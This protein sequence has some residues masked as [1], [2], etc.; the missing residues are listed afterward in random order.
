MAF[1]LLTSM[2]GAMAQDVMTVEKTDGSIVSFPINEVNCVSFS[3]SQVESGKFHGPQRVFAQNQLKAFGREDKYRYELTYDA[4]GF[5]TKLLYLRLND[6]RQERWDIA[7][8]G[9]TITVSI[10]KNDEFRGNGIG[11]IGSNGYLSQCV[12]PGG[13][14][15]EFTYNN[16]EQLTSISVSEGSKTETL[17]FIWQ[18]GNILQGSWGGTPTNISY[19]SDSNSI[20]NVAGVMEYD[21][22]M[23]IDMDDWTLF[24]YIGLIGK[25][26]RQ[27]P[28]SWTHSGSSRTETGTNQWSL[29]AQGRA[30][31]LINTQT[32]SSSSGSSS[33]TS[34]TFFWEW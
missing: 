1:L 32:E 7:Y 20:E 28:M 29:D 25:G 18:G 11:T 31:K 16:N 27:L 26:T 8:E 22:G 23:G 14:I 12:G 4:Q 5:V 19:A 24:Y 6:N 33:Q 15:M 21:E 9:N 10:Y 34:L 13:E 3:T 2:V 30:V 17:S